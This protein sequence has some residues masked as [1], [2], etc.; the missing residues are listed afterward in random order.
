MSSPVS[1]SAGT[2]PPASR[3]RARAILLGVGFAAVLGMAFVARAHRPR[4]ALAFYGHVPTFHLLDQRGAPFSD[5]SMLGHVNVV[6]FIFTRCASS[7]PR[8]TARMGELQGRLE[9]DRGSARL[10]SFSVDPDNDTPPVLSEY[11]A[12]AHA[13]P[14]RWSFLTGPVDDVKAAVVSGFKIALEKQPREGTN[15]YDVTHGDW[16]VLVDPGGNLRGYY[17][18]D[19]SKDLDVLTAD[20]QRL[21]PAKP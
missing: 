7:C 5:G 20:I 2:S 15:D 12:K 11:A 10:I 21:E 8:L 6:D 13:D 1:E 3:L 9:R 17:A 4:P 18:V 16:F 19:D 14:E